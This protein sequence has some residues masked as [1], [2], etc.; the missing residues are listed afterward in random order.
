[1][2]SSLNFKGISLTKEFAQPLM[3]AYHAQMHKQGVHSLS[4]DWYICFYHQ[5]L[6][7]SVILCHLWTLA[8][9]NAF[10]QDRHAHRYLKKM[11]L[12]KDLLLSRLSM[13]SRIR[14]SRNY[15]FYFSSSKP[16]SFS[17]FLPANKNLCLY[18]HN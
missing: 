16:D 3:C 2:Y 10:L 6:H 13:Q 15:L 12:G 9:Y 17:G 11:L 7:L 1:M 18:A 14:W 4:S 8:L 5:S